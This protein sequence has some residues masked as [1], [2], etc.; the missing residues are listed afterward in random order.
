MSYK[1]KEVSE[2]VG[3]SVRTLHHYDQA[4][5]LKP[6]SVTASGYRLYTDFELEKLQQI[7]FFRELGFGLRQIKCILDSPGF[8]RVQVLAAQKKLLLEKKKRLEAIIDLVEQTLNAVKGGL[9]MN[10]KDMFPAFDMSEIEKNQEQFA[11]ETRQKYGDTEAYRESLKKAA[12]FKKEDWAVI[13]ARGNDIYQEL[14]GLMDLD[15]AD[16]KVQQAI[17]AWRQHITD[18]YYNCTPEIFR[19]LGDLYV[20]DERFT[21]S[22]D[23]TKHGLARFMSEA[24]HIYCDNL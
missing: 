19:G 12:S 21:A 24:M 20:Q 7:L 2:I 3:I 15:P 18:S 1:I 13:S 4:G 6:G 14:A 23:K 11:E 10:K 16:Q 17:G 22:I 9:V 5:L 8:D